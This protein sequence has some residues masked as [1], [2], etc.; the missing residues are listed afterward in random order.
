MRTQRSTSAPAHRGSRAGVAGIAAGL[1]VLAG[2]GSSG[3]SSAA[4]GP[5]DTAG[6]TV[7]V[8]D[9]GGM[10][11]LATASGRTLYSSDQESGKVLCK[12][13]ACQAVWVP[14]TVA[15]GTKPS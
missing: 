5:D 9:A 13:Q 8:R 1:L 15:S 12:S 11:V 2:C 10:S 7:T 3:G 6:T 14:L 4:A